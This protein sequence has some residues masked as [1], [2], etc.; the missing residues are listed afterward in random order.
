MRYRLLEHTADIRIEAFGKDINEIFENSAYALF[1]QITDIGIVRKRGTESITL[2]AGSQ[3]TLLVDYLSEL[4]FLCSTMH[5]LFCDFS[6]RVNGLRLSSTV[7]GEKIDRR[8][9][10]LK[11]D[12]KAVTYHMLELNIDKGYARF[13]IDV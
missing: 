10:V 9:H 12:V 3:D 8:R 4:I 5:F 6:V 7:K 11:D 1:D 13:I 2:E